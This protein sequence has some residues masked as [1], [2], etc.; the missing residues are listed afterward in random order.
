MIVKADTIEIVDCSKLSD[1]K[2]IG[3]SEELFILQNS[4]VKQLIK[5]NEHPN[6]VKFL[7]IYNGTGHLMIQFAN[8]G[9][10]RGYLQSKAKGE[11]FAISWAELIQIAE[12]IVLGLQHLH[13]NNIIHGNLRPE[14]I[15]INDNKVLIANFGFAWN[16]EESLRPS[17]IEDTLAYIEPQCY[18]QLEKKVDIN[19]KS[20]INSLGVLLW[21]LT[22]GIPPFS[23]IHNKL[24]IS[25]CIA[26][27]Y[28]EEVIPETPINYI[29]LYKK[30]WD[31]K[32]NKRPKLGEILSKLRQLNG[33]TKVIMNII[34]NHASNL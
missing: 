18:I 26:Q 31:T 3:K 29:K 15:L 28:R 4:V 34:L 23:N 30:C 33:E 12:Q 8:G 32:P 24:A 2:E 20:D 7:G 19:V 27:N 10:L 11:N 21:E 6:I 22:S 5:A 1:I 9:N 16:L 25:T 17:C 13:N 14:N